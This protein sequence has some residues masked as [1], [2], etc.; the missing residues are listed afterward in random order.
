MQCQI[1]VK[2]GTMLIQ[3]DRD[4]VD[5]SSAMPQHKDPRNF[6]SQFDSYGG[7]EAALTLSGK[8]KD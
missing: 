1:Q 3:A 6:I 7:D 8:L 4:Q 2:N 5:S